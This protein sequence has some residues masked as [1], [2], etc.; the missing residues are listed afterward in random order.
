MAIWEL[1]GVTLV[2]GFEKV[3]MWLHEPEGLRKRMDGLG[4]LLQAMVLSWTILDGL[5]LSLLRAARL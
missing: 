4:E 2:R 1:C 5:T 3:F